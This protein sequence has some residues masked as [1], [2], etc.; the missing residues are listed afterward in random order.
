MGK[1]VFSTPLP[2][3]VERKTNADAIN[4]LMKILA[5]IYYMPAIM[6]PKKG[7]TIAAPP[8]KE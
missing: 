3:P 1:A 8:K 5:N 2:V 4:L 6:F 7:E